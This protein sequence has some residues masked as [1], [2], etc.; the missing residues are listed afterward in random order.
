MKILPIYAYNTQNKA[1][2]SGN[3]HKY[4]LADKNANPSFKAADPGT[5]LIL[6]GLRQTA[7]A[8]KG[9]R[10]T[11]KILKYKKTVVNIIEHANDYKDKI[12]SLVI[13]LSNI[14]NNFDKFS[15]YSTWLLWRKDTIS[16]EEIKKQVLTKIMTMLEDKDYSHQEA[17]KTFLTSLIMRDEYKTPEFFFFF[18]VLP[19]Q[20]Y[21]EYKRGI[22]DKILFG[23]E[24]QTKGLK[25]NSDSVFNIN[26]AKS[27]LP[28][29][30]SDYAQKLQSGIELN[31]K[32]LFESIANKYKNY[33]D[34]AFIRYSEDFKDGQNKLTSITPYEKVLFNQLLISS[35]FDTKKLSKSLNIREYLAKIIIDDFKA[36][37]L[38]DK[39]KN[40][41]A[42]KGILTKRLEEKFSQD[43]IV[44]KYEKD[45]D[46]LRVKINNISSFL[47]KTGDLKDELNKDFE[48]PTY[49]LKQEYEEAIAYE[50]SAI[51]RDHDEYL[52]NINHVILET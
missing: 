35:N 36:L 23:R 18:Y 14:S 46:M 26:L 44:S 31:Q 42:K 49:K 20:Y 45:S 16:I 25:N 38:A 2:H 41:D 37:A 11:S 27:I 13:E 10:K 15:S 34:E 47:E 33:D 22:L 3:I 6:A 40:I 17:K 1:N 29:E 9:V 43:I 30:K 7:A 4:Y 48:Y 50:N 19:H 32:L 8:V 5:Y 39:V 12:H 51:E 52:E 28:F 21:A 24:Y